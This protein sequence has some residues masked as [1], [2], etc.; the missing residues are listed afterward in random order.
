MEVFLVVVVLRP[1]KKQ[2]D[3]EGSVPMV[4]VQP[5]AVMAKDEQQA[6]MKAVRF[7]PP[8]HADKD[9][10]LEVRILPFRSATR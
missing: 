3:E 1:T 10:R 6:A 4:I 9:D 7:V 2:V 5:Q 8:E